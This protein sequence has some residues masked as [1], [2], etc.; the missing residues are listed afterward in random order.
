MNAT[1]DTPKTTAGAVSANGHGWWIAWGVLLILAGVLAVLMP[2]VAALATALV[3]GWLLLLG[4]VFELAHAIQVRHHAGFGWRLL[5]ALLTLVLGLAILVVPFAGVA[6]LALLVCVF[7]LVGG[8]VRALL[9]FRLRPQ[10]GWGWVLFDGVVSILVAILIG[11]GWP[12]SSLPFIGLLTGF[13]LIANGLW[14][15]V[16]A[17]FASRAAILSP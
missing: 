3:F 1:P 2:E 5:S 16:L 7:L 10:R 9:A 6:S 14:R 4:G 15:I 12:Q 11:I 13:W 8:I 17:R